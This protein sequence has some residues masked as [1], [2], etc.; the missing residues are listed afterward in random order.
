MS[1]PRNAEEELSEGLRRVM[2]VIQAYCD[3][4]GYAPTVREVQDEAGLPSTNSAWRA[5]LKL[6]ARRYIRRSEGVSRGLVILRRVEEIAERPTP[7]LG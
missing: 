2:L 5:L 6:E 3:R 1:E 4:C 7:P